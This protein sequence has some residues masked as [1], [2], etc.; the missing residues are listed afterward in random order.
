MEP[1]EGMD[2]PEREVGIRMIK[3]EDFRRAMLSEPAGTLEREFGV[4][5][6]EGVTVEIHEE[7]DDVI[8]LVVPGRPKGLDRVPD[9]ELDDTIA[10]MMP[11][12]PKKRT[13]CC[14]CGSSSG[15]TFT[16]WQQGC[17]CV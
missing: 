16:S 9:R 8:H 2:H 10:E 12:D 17:G 7:T 4:K 14:T 6:P 11:A 15:Q 3:D 1:T 13:N 5:I